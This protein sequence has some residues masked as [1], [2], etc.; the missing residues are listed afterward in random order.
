MIYLAHIPPWLLVYIFL[1]VLFITATGLELYLDVN[2]NKYISPN[3]FPKGVPA[4]VTV[5]DISIWS[6]YFINSVWVP[7]LVFVYGRGFILYIVNVLFL[8]RHRNS[9]KLEAIMKNISSATRVPAVV[10][11]SILLFVYMCVCLIFDQVP[12]NMWHTSDMPVPSIMGYDGYIFATFIWFPRITE[13]MCCVQLIALYLC[14][15][16]H[17][18]IYSSYLMKENVILGDQTIRVRYL[19]KCRYNAELSA[20][21]EHPPTPYV[22]RLY[23]LKVLH[24][25]DRKIVVAFRR[26]NSYQVPRTFMNAECQSLWS[27]LHDG[28]VRS[29]TIS[30]IPVGSSVEGGIICRSFSSVTGCGLMDFDQLR[31]LGNISF[32]DYGT[33]FGPAPDQPGWYWVNKD[34]MCPR[35]TNIDGY[36]NIFASTHPR[37]KQ[38]NELFGLN[39]TLNHN[40]KR[41]GPALTNIVNIFDH[42]D[43][44]ELKLSTDTVFASQLDFWPPEAADWL[45]RTRQW[46]SQDV[47]DQISQQPCFLVHKPPSTQ[48]EDMDKWSLSF[49]LA[50]QMLCLRRSEGMRLTYF[51]FKAMFYKCLHVTLDDKEFSSYLCKTVMM[52]ALEELPPGQWTEENLLTNLLL[53]FSKLN[54]HIERKHLPHYFIPDLNV[55]RDIPE[56][57]FAIIR[58]RFDRYD[59]VSL[60]SLVCFDLWGIYDWD[61]FK[62][63]QD[64][65]NFI[66][67]LNIINDRTMDTMGWKPSNNHDNQEII[68]QDPDEDIRKRIFWCAV[69][70]GCDITKPYSPMSIP[71]REEFSTEKEYIKHL[72]NKSCHDVLTDFETQLQDVECMLQDNKDTHHTIAGDTVYIHT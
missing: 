36:V 16:K 38:V 32:T 6:K 11:R 48:P 49:T 39:V 61:I 21:I 23:L 29:G 60:P 31:V 53:L 19:R 22:S 72:V 34:V 35:L 4:G 30:Y 7:H 5:V 66:S 41:S 25:L 2:I 71:L 17:D 58:E 43:N 13:L 56:S 27:R 55:M 28:I 59:L 37:P 68:I 15:A 57:M 12:L 14:E 42:T 46:P 67:T 3:V 50:E 26:W 54:E 33:T 40:M 52:W 69:H 63:V 1:L 9:D 24:E 20:W 10:Y 65:A 45:T 70:H 64:Q 47:V 51:C 44:Y 62:N 18:T 8:E